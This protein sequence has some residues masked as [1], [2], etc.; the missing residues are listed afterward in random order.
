MGFHPKRKQND[1][2]LFAQ[3]VQAVYPQAIEP[4]PFDQELDPNTQ[5]F[6]SKSGEDYLTVNYS[7]LVPLLVE[8][9]KELRAQVE[10]QAAMINELKAGRINGKQ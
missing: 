1:S 2:G 8:A 4:A 7:K 6:K 3:D 10:N 5:A 9:I